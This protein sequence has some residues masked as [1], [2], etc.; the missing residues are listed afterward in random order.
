MV[1][2]WVRSAFMVLKDA[3]TMGKAESK[4]LDEMIAKVKKIYLLDGF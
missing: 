3:F 1:V 4:L 2:R